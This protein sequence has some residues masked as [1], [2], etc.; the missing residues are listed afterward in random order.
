[1]GRDT[2]DG[3]I[4]GGRRGVDGG[5]GY[6]AAGRAGGVAAMPVIVLTLV[7]VEGKVP[8]ADKFVVAQVDGRIVVGIIIIAPTHIFAFAEGVGV[9]VAV[10]S[11]VGKGGVIKVDS[12]VDDA[13]DDALAL[14]G[15]PCRRAIPD[16]RCADPCRAH[17]RI[18]VAQEIA[19]H[20][21]DTGQGR[22]FQGLLAREAH[23]EAVEGRAVAMQNLHIASKALLHGAENLSLFSSQVVQVGQAG[24]GI[25]VQSRLSGHRGAGS[26]QAADLAAIA[27]QRRVSQA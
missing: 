1:M 18:W 2:R 4:Y 5:V 10:A 24:W 22:S 15:H 14:G 23:G 19:L 25:G 3:S 7:A 8:G 6:V 21:G 9:I 26:R 13:D 17:I 20:V 16:T 11:N 27:R 12:S